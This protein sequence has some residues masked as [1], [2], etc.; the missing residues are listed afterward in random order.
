MTEAAPTGELSSWHRSPAGH[1]GITHDCYEKGTGPGVILMPE[2]PGITPLVVGFADHLVEQGFTVVI[3]SLFGT[4]GRPESVRYAT[5][6]IARACVSTEFRAFAT[7]ADRPIT[8]YLRGLAQELAARTPGRGVGIIG[9]CF[10]GGFA[11]A[12]A[13]DDVVNA[14]VMSQP[15][16]PLALGATRRRDPG[17]S[18]AALDRIAE[19]TTT[20]GLCVLGM[21]FSQD[22]M[23]PSDRF[24][25]L[26]ARLGDAF[27]VIELDSAPGND[28]GFGKSAHSVLTREQPRPLALAARDRTVE[29][30]R[31]QLTPAT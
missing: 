21:R 25:T 18:P 6:V 10:T 30:L 12:A 19:R 3:P 1:A 15:S 22:G 14:P 16:L 28:G 7:N 5:G 31:R 29:F 27:E 2:I 24:T 9:M 11:L 26:R 13:V 23:A 17:V 4:P 20:S 8:A